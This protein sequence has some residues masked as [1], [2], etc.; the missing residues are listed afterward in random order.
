[1]LLRNVFYFKA[2]LRKNIEQKQSC[3]SKRAEN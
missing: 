1:M 2:N 3:V